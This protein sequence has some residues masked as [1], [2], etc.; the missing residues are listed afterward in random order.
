[1]MDRRH[2]IVGFDI[3]TSSTKAAIADT[4]TGTIIDTRTFHYE[5]AREAAPGVM[6]IAVYET[7]LLSAITSL[8]GDYEIDSIGLTVQM[9]SILRKTE[10]GLM[11]YQWNSLWARDKQIEV[12]MKDPLV[13]SGC[14][15]DTIYPGYKLGTMTPEMRK[16]FLPY[17]IKEHLICLLTG[18]LVTD[19]TI[20]SPFG[21]FDAVKREWNLPLI[22]S[23]GIDESLLPKAVP[24]SVPVGPIDTELLPGFHAIL[25]PGLG[26]G[27]SA[28]FACRDVSCLCANL[29]T[30]MAVRVITDKPDFSDENGLW[31]YAFDDTLYTTGG[32]S[33]N[34]CSVFHWGDQFDL[35]TEAPEDLVDTHDVMFFP[36]LHGERMPYWSSDLR[37]TFIGL[38]VFDDQKVLRSAVLKAVAFTFCRI[39]RTL[40]KVSAPDQPL[41]MAGGGTKN[42]AVLSV[43][44]GC[45]HRDLYLQENEAFLGSI[46]AAIA[47]GI[48]TGHAVHPDTKIAEI[49]HPTGAYEAEY[50]RWL[51]MAEK[52][53]QF[54]N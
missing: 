2:V 13:R 10:D 23:L 50:E 1:M 24:Y 43:I 49:I 47:S 40:E 18:K 35:R 53:T 6:P 5:N 45:V 30:S 41:V 16:E 26:D 46:G 20:A 9:Y 39:A 52:M 31:N 15:P 22:R 42:R 33:S 28:S 38:Q 12:E 36:W 54:Y 7:A 11:A 25:T 17:G 3:G 48:A 37:G 34:S 21:L 14:R 32:I 51:K 29:G 27:P 19:Y 8:M 44:A 4:D